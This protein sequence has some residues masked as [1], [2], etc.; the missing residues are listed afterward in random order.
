MILWI[1]F[2]VMAVVAIGFVVTPLYRHQKKMTPLI[3]VVV[4]A[5]VAIS[6]GLY[7]SKGSPDAPSA[8]DGPADVGDALANL[9][10]KLKK[11]PDNLEGWK[12]LGR[13]YVAVENFAGA[14]GALEHVIKLDGGQD[15]E[16][17]VA[18]GESLLAGGGGY[19][20]SGEAVRFPLRYESRNLH[21]HR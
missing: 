11:D 6:A 13:S 20:R 15:A 8:G 12:M 18:L 16:T 3:A 10:K 5:V 2:I 17:L 19:S 21:W 14:V 7:N 4:V 1:F 9:A